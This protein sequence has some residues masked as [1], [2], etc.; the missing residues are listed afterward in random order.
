ML[1]DKKTRRLQMRDLK[2][3]ITF[4]NLLQEAQNEL[5]TQAVSEGKTALGYTCYYIRKF[6]LIWMVFPCD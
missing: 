1:F 2:H 3:L 4:E 6:C 5:V